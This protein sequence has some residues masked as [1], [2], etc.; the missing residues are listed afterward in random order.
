[1]VR[2][3][4]AVDTP[5]RTAL[6]IAVIPCAGS[7]LGIPICGEPYDLSSLKV[8]VSSGVIWS[9]AVKQALLEGKEMLLIDVVQRAPNGKA[10][11]AWAK[12]HARASMGLG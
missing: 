4:E 9:S 11:Y 2:L 12:E 8:I 1:V 6:C 3:P 7:Q 10:D 5:L